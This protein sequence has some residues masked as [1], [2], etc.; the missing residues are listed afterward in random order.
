MKPHFVRHGTSGTPSP[1]Q[2][3]EWDVCAL[4]AAGRRGRRPLHKIRNGIYVLLFAAGRRGRR[5]RQN[6]LFPL[7]RK[8]MCPR[9]IRRNRIRFPQPIY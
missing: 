5:P 7:E 1:T 2:E 3:S 4:F 6:S 9:T 8:E